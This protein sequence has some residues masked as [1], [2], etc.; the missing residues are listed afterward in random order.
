METLV[1]AVGPAVTHKRAPSSPD[2][3]LEGPGNDCLRQPPTGDRAFVESGFQHRS[4]SSVLE[5]ERG[6]E[7]KCIE[8]MVSKDWRRW[9]WFQIQRSNTKLQGTWKIKQTQNCQGITTPSSNWPKR[10]GE[11][12]FPVRESKTVVLWIF[13]EL[14]ENIEI[15]P[16]KSTKYVTCWMLCKY[17]TCCVN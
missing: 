9:L 8:R 17:V 13:R 14:Q 11:P 7:F 15:S 1:P 6:Y 4:Y 16:L 5:Q 3:S 2:W 12:W 10:H